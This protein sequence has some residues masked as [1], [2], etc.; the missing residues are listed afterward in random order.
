MQEDFL[1]KLS[2]ELAQQCK[3]AFCNIVSRTVNTTGYKI[4]L[5]EDRGL[6]DAP[7]IMMILRVTTKNG[8]KIGTLID[9]AS[10]TNNITHA[11]AEQL[12]LKSENITPLV[13]HG[14]GGK[15]IS[16]ETKR[17]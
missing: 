7:V 13:V 8:Q 3:K 5:K 11:A 10:Y 9:L 16:V 14:I 17:N 2:P 6:E 12:N 4:G 1:V 15:K